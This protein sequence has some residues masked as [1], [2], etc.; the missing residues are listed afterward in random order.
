MT[1]PSDA[2]DPALLR[3]PSLAG[4]DAVAPLV[5]PAPTSPN[6]AALL[7][8]FTHTL[9]SQISVTGKTAPSAFEAFTRLSAL[10]AN[11]EKAAQ[12]LHLSIMA[13]AGI[14]A[15]NNGQSRF[16]ITSER[17]GQQATA[18]FTSRIAEGY[19]GTDEER[20][21]ML[22]AGLMIVQYKVTFFSTSRAP[23]GQICRGD[24]SGFQWILCHLR[25]L[26]ALI[27]RPD[28]EDVLPDSMQFHL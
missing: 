19:D 20:L 26:G 6:D 1:L 17:L 13:W 2:I 28:A 10:P 14:H 24:V 9:S 3:T 15:V 12:A 5:A 21:T 8:Y 7:S 18:L 27:F 11:G 25:L 16:E 22:A 23:D 4:T